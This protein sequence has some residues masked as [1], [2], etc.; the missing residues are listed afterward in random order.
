MIHYQIKARNLLFGIFVQHFN[1]VHL[2]HYIYLIVLSG[3]TLARFLKFQENCD[4]AMVDVR[5]TL[6]GRNYMLLVF[7]VFGNLHF[8]LSN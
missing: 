7:V 4:S 2:N 3:Q 5:N 6:D 8:T 1:I